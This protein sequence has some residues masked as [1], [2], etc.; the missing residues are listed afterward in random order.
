MMKTKQLIQKLKISAKNVSYSLFV[1]NLKVI[2]IGMTRS[3]QVNSPT[4]STISFFFFSNIQPAKPKNSTS[5]TFCNSS[6]FLHNR[7]LILELINSIQC[8]SPSLTPLSL[9]LLLTSF[10]KLN[11]KNSISVIVQVYLLCTKTT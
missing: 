4:I 6:I 3:T 1:N 5:Y 8:L 10:P 7:T 11:F 9:P 2:F